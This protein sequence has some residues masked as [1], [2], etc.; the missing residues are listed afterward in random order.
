MTGAAT[1]TISSGKLSGLYQAGGQVAV[2]KGV[3]MPVLQSA[4]CAGSRPAASPWD[5]LRPARRYGSP[6]FQ[7]DPG[8]GIFM[9]NLIGGLGYSWLKTGLLKL[10]L[11]LYP[12][13]L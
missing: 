13:S 5:G 4:S 10:F 2:F 6:A 1:V 12:R 11:H 8:S 3:P 7:L 9:N